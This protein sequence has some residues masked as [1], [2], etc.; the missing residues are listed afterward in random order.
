MAP[1]LSLDLAFEAAAQRLLRHLEW[2]AQGFSMVFLFADVNA[3]TQLAAWLD[4][5]LAPQGHA[6]QQKIVATDFLDAPESEVDALTT[7][8]QTTDQPLGALWWALHSY[9]GNTQWSR[10]RQVNTHH[11]LSNVGWALDSMGKVLR[12]QGK[13]EPAQAM[14][15]EALGLGRKLLKLWGVS[16]HSLKGLAMSL[17]QTAQTAYMLGERSLAEARFRESAQVS[18]Q[19]LQQFGDTR[20]AL[21]DLSLALA[22]LGQLS[23]EQGDFSQAEVLYRECL[24]LERRLVPWPADRPELAARLGVALKQVARLPP[25]D[26]ALRSEAIQLFETLAQQHP[27]VLGCAQQLDM[28]RSDNFILTSTPTSPPSP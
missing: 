13:L 12:V 21:S 9:A 4:E 16:C 28:L 25:G 6:L 8:I 20:E 23:A 2:Q 19:S 14:F 1:P 17:V 26:P 5:R 15:Q 24:A 18:R 3:A 22:N 11:A 10:A 7:L 27:A